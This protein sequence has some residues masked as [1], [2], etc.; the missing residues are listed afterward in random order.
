MDA[1]AHTFQTWTLYVCI[2]ALAALSVVIFF[3]LVRGPVK[4]AL[5]KVRR[6]PAFQQ[7]LCAVFVCGAVLYGGS[8]NIISYDGGIRQNSDTPSLITNNLVRITWERVPGAVLPLTSPVYID[9]R[10][11][12]STNEW[13]LLGETIVSAFMWEGTVANATNYD[14]NVWAYYIPPEPVHTNGTWSFSTMRDKK[15]E[16]I[17]PMRAVVKADI[18]ILSPPNMK[19]TK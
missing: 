19:G 6:L 12:G 15:G 8:K 7:V 13:T 18:E 11:H 9:Y 5:D 1:L 14:Y 17:L 10:Q 3:E 2:V 16:N 4:V